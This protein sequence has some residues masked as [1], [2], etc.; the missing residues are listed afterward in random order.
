MGMNGFPGVFPPLSALSLS[1]RKGEGL[2]KTS[3]HGR[4][5]LNPQTRPTPPSFPSGRRSLP[6][7]VPSHPENTIPSQAGPGQRP[8]MGPEMLGDPVVQPRA[9]PGQ[10]C[11]GVGWP[12]HEEEPCPVPSWAACPGSAQQSVLW[13]RV[14]PISGLGLRPGQG[15]NLNGKP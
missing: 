6:P 14:S 5:D 4:G 13:V 11:C 2:I 1:P 7:A 9:L 15:S 12:F 10:R 8:C 3:P